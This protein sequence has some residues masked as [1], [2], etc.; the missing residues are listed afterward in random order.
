LETNLDVQ[1]AIPGMPEGLLGNVS[2]AMWPE[3]VM[4]GAAGQFART[5]GKYLETPEAFLFMGYLTFLGHIISGKVT[6]KSEI[7][8]QPRLYT[9]LLGESA[10]TRK[11][12]AIN[13]CHD[14]F[15]EAVEREV[16]PVCGVG[17]AEGLAKGLERQ[18]R[19]ILL[20]DELQALVQKC[21]IDSSA[22]LTCVSTLYEKD[23]YQ[24]ET[25]RGS[26]LVD[27]GQLSILAASTLDTYETM[28]K[29]QFLNIGFLNRLFVVIGQGRR[30]FAIPKRIP[31]VERRPLLNRLQEV[32]GFVNDLAHTGC[33]ALPIDPQAEAIFEQ[34]YHTVQGSIFSK[35]LDTY[36]HRLMVLLAANAMEDRVTPEVA[37]QTVTLL[38]Y[39]LSARQQADPIRADTQVARIEEKIR[40][41]VGA[42]PITKRNLEQRGHKNRTGSYLWKA[43]VKNL[44]GDGEI[45]LDSKTKTYHPCSL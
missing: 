34:W 7:A 1:A 27:G 10:D 17:S 21:Q 30:K 41:L 26:V 11:S 28:F 42:G 24:N 29:S 33:F 13:K 31:D 19:V 5:Y 3:A 39:Q 2:G 43:A 37:D 15:R 12:T 35:R 38:R 23:F 6:L 16:N 22:L 14:F 18:K 9:V 32:L 40:R 45:R 25:S 36:G 20:L 4:T 44:E 8:P